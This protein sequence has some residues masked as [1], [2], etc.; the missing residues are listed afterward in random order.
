MLNFQPIQYNKEI[1]C[2][3]MKSTTEKPSYFPTLR[4]ATHADRSSQTIPD[5]IIP[6][7]WFSAR[8]ELDANDVIWK[9]REK[10]TE[11]A[12][13]VIRKWSL[14]EVRPLWLDQVSDQDGL[15][16]LSV[17]TEQPLSFFPVIMGW[18]KMRTACFQDCWG[19]N[20]HQLSPGERTGLSHEKA[21]PCSGWG[22][23]G[24]RPWDELLPVWEQLF[25]DDVRKLGTSSWLLF[26]G[27]WNKAKL[28][29][30][31]RK[32]TP[33]PVCKWEPFRRERMALFSLKS[34]FLDF[35]SWWKAL[36]TIIV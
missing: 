21:L 4:E 28:I 20:R 30:D 1:W 16:Q 27:V 12:L 31:S 24:L 11:K 25:A 2:E 14:K 13:E 6:S 22:N 34:V 15:L 33:L 17:S 19:G 7:G 5:I 23:G 26:A 18:S 35:F 8:R 29:H 3:P 9:L 36:L 10:A 32:N